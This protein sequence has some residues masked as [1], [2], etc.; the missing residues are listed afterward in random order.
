MAAGPR[1]RAVGVVQ[2]VVSPREMARL[3]LLLD[4]I[5]WVM[6]GYSRRLPVASF[7]R[8]KRLVDGGLD[9]CACRKRRRSPPGS[10]NHRHCAA[11]PTVQSMGA[12]VLM[13]IANFVAFVWN[14]GR[15]AA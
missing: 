7:F 10:R 14:G 8:Y 6:L 1:L 15:A 4:V 2:A 3:L 12:Q 13:L 9:R 11:F 5:D